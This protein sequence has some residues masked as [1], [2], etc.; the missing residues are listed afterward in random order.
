MADSAGAPAAATTIGQ[1]VLEKAAGRGLLAWP[2][3]RLGTFPTPLRFAPRLSA[4]AGTE[5]WLKRD[6]LTG[7]GL[8]GNKVRGLEFLLADAERLRCDSLIT[9]AGPG[10]N[11]AMLAA[12]AART[13]G[14][15]PVVVYY[16]DP[17][18]ATGNM[19]LAKAIGA[20]IRFTGEADRASVDRA[21]DAVANEMRQAGR[22]PYPL[23]RGGATA[24]G[25]LGYAAASLELTT[26]LV[27]LGLDPAALWTATGSCGTQA[28][29]HAGAAWLRSRYRVVGVTVS[30]PAMECRERVSRLAAEAAELLD[31]PTP[32]IG[33]T[34]LDG[35][36][37]G[38]GRRDPDSDAAAE[39]VA[40][41]EGVFLD[42]VFAAKA[43]VRLLAD[44][45]AGAARGPLV[46]LVS[47]GAPT[48]FAPGPL[49]T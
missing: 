43:M 30:R 35:V 12:L 27:E 32:I 10:S 33:P 28:G 9:G 5:I 8:G 37:L 45:R 22:R 4:A 15:D 7:F 11:W 44:V 13:Q 1:P 16:G 46:F 18:P 42:P 47:G 39:L 36:G 3:I 34:V 6:D 2:R 40:R 26:Q 14:L 29:L 17:V 31:G 49:Q 19:Q 21:I 20:E 25:A 23:G 24:I 48:L 41:T 38:Y